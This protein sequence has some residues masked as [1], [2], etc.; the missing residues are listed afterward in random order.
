M[1][2]NCL[3]PVFERFLHDSELFFEVL[4]VAGNSISGLEIAKKWTQDTSLI[5][6][7]Y[8]FFD[9]TQIE[10]KERMVESG[11]VLWRIAKQTPMPIEPF[12]YDKVIF[13]A[14]VLLGSKDAD[15]VFEGVCILAVMT[16][17]QD[18]RIIDMVCQDKTLGV[19]C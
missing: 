1:Q 9:R 12:W 13:C 15:M 10:G 5:Q 11:W 16:R 7:I 19:L 6:A 17:S 18:E 8:N 2:N 3:W 4:N 14:K